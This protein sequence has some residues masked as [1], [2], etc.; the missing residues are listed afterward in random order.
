MAIVGGIFLLGVSGGSFYQYWKDSEPLRVFQNSF[1]L[2]NPKDINECDDLYVTFQGVVQAGEYRN[3]ELATDEDGK[4]LKAVAYER[5]V[6][7]NLEVKDSLT[8]MLQQLLDVSVW[9]PHSVEQKIKYRY[10]FT[11]TNEYGVSAIITDIDDR[12]GNYDLFE[13]RE[14][15]TPSNPRGIEGQIVTRVK[16]LGTQVSESYLAEGTKVLVVGSVKLK[17]G[18]IY[19]KNRQSTPYYIITTLDEDSLKNKLSDRGSALLPLAT[20]SLFAG[21]GVIYFSRKN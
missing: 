16:E 20:L 5:N 18:K 17:D 1:R 15:Y 7:R 11:I 13:N 2:D 4:Q 10:P 9:A 12:Y 3:C 6:S 14:T 21:L 8:Y 19:I